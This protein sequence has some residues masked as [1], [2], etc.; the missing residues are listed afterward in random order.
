MANQFDV[1]A[2]TFGRIAPEFNGRMAMQ[3]RRVSCTP[4]GNISVRVDGNYN[5]AWL[6]LWIW[7]IA[8]SAGVTSVSI[9]TTGDTGPWHPMLNTFGAAW[10][11]FAQPPHP[12]DV[13]FTTDDGQTATLTAII[14]DGSS[15]YIESNV[16]IMSNPPVW[17]SFV[18]PT[19]FN[20]P[21]QPGSTADSVISQPFG[22]MTQSEDTCDFT[23]LDINFSGAQYSCAEQRAFGKCNSTFLNRPVKQQ[24]LTVEGY[25]PALNYCHRTCQ[26]Q[27]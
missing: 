27:R 24:D 26:D 23:T 5:N 13:L 2:Q 19:S 9:R 12:A 14:N 16:Q 21:V 11:T 4:T 3:Y 17:N 25:P 6:R 8:G 15:G 20:P 7:S 10:E 18:F 22:A 1:Q